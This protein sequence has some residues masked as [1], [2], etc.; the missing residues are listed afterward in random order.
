M[1]NYLPKPVTNSDYKWGLLRRAQSDC[2]GEK[3]NDCIACLGGCHRDSKQSSMV[4]YIQQGE[5]KGL[6]VIANTEVSHLEDKRD[7]VVVFGTTT[8]E[9]E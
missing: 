2:A 1:P 5:K 7:H 3:G 4:T 6:Q 9:H 8:R